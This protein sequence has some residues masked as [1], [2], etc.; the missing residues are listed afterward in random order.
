MSGMEMRNFPSS[1][2]YRSGPDSVGNDQAGSVMLEY[3]L[4]IALIAFVALVSVFYV[5]RATSRSFANID[6]DNSD[7]STPGGP[8]TII[9]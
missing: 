4:I 3:S 2:Y 7:A 6:L 5:G 1:Q 8:E 9:P